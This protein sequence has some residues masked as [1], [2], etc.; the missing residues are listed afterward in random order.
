[1]IMISPQFRQGRFSRYSDYAS[2]L[3]RTIVLYESMYRIE[4]LLNELN[5]YMPTLPEILIA[6]GVWSLGFLVLTALFK[7]ATKVKEE[8]Y[9]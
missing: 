5:E 6:L 4:K 2:Y 9:A 7:M 3:G 1:M 8:T